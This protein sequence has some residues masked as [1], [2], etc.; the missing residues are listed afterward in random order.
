[1]WTAVCSWDSHLWKLDELHLLKLHMKLQPLLAMF[2]IQD[3][4]EVLRGKKL[5]IRMD[6]IQYDQY[7]YKKK[8][9]GPGAHQ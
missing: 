8:I 2:D 3:L 7:P 9:L 6:L 4:K 1:M 5:V